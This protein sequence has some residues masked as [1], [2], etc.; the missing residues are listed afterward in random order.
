MIVAIGL[1]TRWERDRVVPGFWTA[2]AFGALAALQLLVKLNSGLTVT[3]CGAIALL[4]AGGAAR[5]SR[6][7]VFAGALLGTL[8]VLWL[9][10]GQRLEDLGPTSATR[11]RSSRA[12]GRR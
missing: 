6:A 3:V 8:L 9:A 11:T 12:S 5:W 4:V 1:M 7:G 2:A 10:L